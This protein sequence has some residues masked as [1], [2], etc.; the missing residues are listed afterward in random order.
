MPKRSRQTMNNN[1]YDDANTRCYLNKMLLSDDIPRKEKITI[2]KKFSHVDAR[3]VSEVAYYSMLISIGKVSRKETKQS[4]LTVV[5]PMCSYE[6]LKEAHD[7]FNGLLK[8]DRVPYIE[9]IEHLEIFVQ[10]AKQTRFR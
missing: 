8:K 5:A 9:L 3:Y 2:L 10:R 4:I 7:Y 6:Q 1:N